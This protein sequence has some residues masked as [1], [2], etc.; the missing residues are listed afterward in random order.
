LDNKKEFRVGINLN[1]IL[2]N[3]SNTRQNIIL[4]DGDRI[5]VPSVKHTVKTEGALLVP[6][7]IRSEKSM[8]F[9]GYIDKSGG[10]QSK[11]L[12]RK[13]YVIYP[14]GDIASTK[15]FLFF[16]NYP[17]VI[18]GSVIVVPKKEENQNPISTEEVLG[19]TSGFATI[20]LLVDRIFRN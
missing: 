19:V 14:N 12:R 15:S 13:S 17:R 16:K 4:K 1:E 5:I 7:L 8:G 11:A 6:S 2:A 3:P 10:F 18:P 20:A 9:R